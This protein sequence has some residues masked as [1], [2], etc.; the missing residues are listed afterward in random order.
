[1]LFKED[2][3]RKVYSELGRENYALIE[4]IPLPVEHFKTLR[5]ENTTNL[6]LMRTT[7]GFF[8]IYVDEGLE[9]LGN[10][11]PEDIF[12]KEVRDGWRRLDI[13][14]N[15]DVSLTLKTVAAVLGLDGE[16]PRLPSKGEEDKK[17]ESP[18][19]KNTGRFNKVFEKFGKDLTSLASS[20]KLSPVIGREKEIQSIIG[21]IL[22]H[23]K[24]APLLIGEPGVGKSAIVEGM[25]QRIAEGKVILELRES[26]IIEVNLGFLSAGASM[27]GELEERVKNIINAAKED[28][29]VILFFDELHAICS[30]RGDNDV[31]TLLKSDLARGTFKVIGATTYRDYKQSIE[32]DGALAR[33]FQQVLVKEPSEEE[34][35]EILT[36]L[37]PCLE[38]HHSVK[39]PDEVIKEAVKL[40]AWYINDRYLP[41]KAIDL[42]DEACVRMRLSKG[43]EEVSDEAE[44]MDSGL[45]VQKAT[46]DFV[47]G[48]TGMTLEEA[49]Q[50]GEYRLARGILEKRKKPA[51]KLCEGSEGVKRN[52]N[53]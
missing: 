13:P 49:L 26:R 18:V 3:I 43:T 29:R 16:A 44:V 30:T 25:A 40:S 5:E 48:Q 12:T 8:H 14:N 32:K 19:K 45:P 51:Q 28:A 20:G 17:E 10:N 4:R 50:R 34:T 22:K 27:K 46:H 36:G 21:I 24:N 53:A 15:P 39:I 33:R 42:I 23:G 38:A 2:T 9:Y 31:A 47:L 41:D 37:R 1:M 6:L 35:I 11:L 7:K 52:A